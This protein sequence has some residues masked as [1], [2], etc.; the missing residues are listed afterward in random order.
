MIQSVVAGWWL[1][2]LFEDQATMLALRLFL[3]PLSLNQYWILMLLPLVAVICVV[4]KTIKLDDLSQLP[5]QVAALAFQVVFFM[6]LAAGAI[7][8]ITGLL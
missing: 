3:K 1:H 7:W 6:V 4:Y 2:A 8:V 5:V